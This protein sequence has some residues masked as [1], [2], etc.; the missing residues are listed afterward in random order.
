MTRKWH[1]HNEI[2][3]PKTVDRDRKTQTKC[4]FILKYSYFLSIADVRFMGLS[5]LYLLLVLM[6]QAQRMERTMGASGLVEYTIV[7]ER[8]SHILQNGRKNAHE[9][10]TAEVLYICSLNSA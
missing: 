7:G 3:T 5:T 6:V 9:R 2:S 1:K 4:I 8:Q 10:H